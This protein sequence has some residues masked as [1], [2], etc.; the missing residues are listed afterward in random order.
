MHLHF[1]HGDYIKKKFPSDHPIIGISCD[2]GQEC[3]DLAN[4]IDRLFSPIKM[5][6]G[7]KYNC[8]F[9]QNRNIYVEI[10]DQPN[11]KAIDAVQDA[12][13]ELEDFIFRY[14]QPWWAI[15]LGMALA[16]FTFLLAI[17]L[18]GLWKLLVWLHKKFREEL[19]WTQLQAT[20]AVSG[21][22]ALTLTLLFFM[23]GGTQLIDPSQ[24]LSG[25][26]QAQNYSSGTSS[27]SQNNQ[28]P[29]VSD[30]AGSPQDSNADSG[31]LSA[32]NIFQ[33]TDFPLDSCG[34]SLPT[35]PQEFPVSFYPVY[36]SM[37][38][39]NLNEMTRSFCRDAYAMT[40]KDVEKK[41]IQV[42]SFTN[43]DRAEDFKSYLAQFFSG[44]EVGEPTIV[45]KKP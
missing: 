17:S 1:G 10:S 11:E 9:D 20:G 42:A 26:Q 30:S 22:A 34:D 3:R 16:A 25:S 39:E 23:F 6:F 33:D 19:G 43:L 13:R 5:R 18:M 12:K 44:V 45:E 29:V 27:A 37:T 35:N 4:K 21:I 31:S 2:E 38:D 8:G 41:A 32:D 24:V 7:V 14:G 28:S 15:L 36:V 40:R